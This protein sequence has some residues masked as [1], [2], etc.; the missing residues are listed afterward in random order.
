MAR[1]NLRGF[2]LFPFMQIQNIEAIFLILSLASLSDI[3]ILLRII[4]QLKPYK[5]LHV[6][7]LNLLIVTREMNIRSTPGNSFYIIITPQCA[8]GNHY[9]TVCGV[10]LR[11]GL[12][13]C[14]FF[15]FQSKSSFIIE[16]IYVTS[17]L[18]RES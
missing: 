12:A 7:L 6:Q 8:K 2:T 11:F 14:F 5:I 16:G 13:N 17:S 3:K 1:D 4:C 9:N 18:K 10:L 15:Y